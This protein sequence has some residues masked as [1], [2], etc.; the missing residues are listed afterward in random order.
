MEKDAFY[1]AL[2]N[3][4]YSLRPTQPTV[5][6]GDF[7]AISGTEWN[8]CQ[9]VVGPYGSG[10]RKDNSERLLSFCSGAGLRIAG[11]WF[12]R[13]TIHRLP[14]FSNDGVTAKEIDHVLVNTRW[15]ILRNC[16]VYRSLEF[17]TDHLPVV[18]TLAIRLKW[19]SQ[20]RSPICAKFNLKALQDKTI[21][22]QFEVGIQNRF[23]VLDDD[24]DNWEAL[25][26]SVQEVAKE[27]LGLKT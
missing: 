20:K 17:D 10:T 27:V 8:P 6:L 25:H 9:R 4:Y 2:D 5:I 21:R 24:L 22:K 23:S 26:D 7:N 15:T 16:R 1:Q 14:W 19:L 3:L 13:K 12:K 11:S 18:S